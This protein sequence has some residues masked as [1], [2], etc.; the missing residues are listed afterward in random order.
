MNT[1]SSKHIWYTNGVTVLHTIEQMQK[2]GVSHSTQTHN[3]VAHSQCSRRKKLR[4]TQDDMQNRKENAV[5]R[6]R[7]KLEKRKQKNEQ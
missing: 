2:K 7:K 1:N 4:I 3:Q 6:L 5:A